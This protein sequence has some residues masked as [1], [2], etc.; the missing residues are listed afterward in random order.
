[1]VLQIG[2]HVHIGR[3]RAHTEAAYAEPERTLHGLRLQVAI[4]QLQ[5]ELT[6]SRR[7]EQAIRDEA[8][9]VSKSGGMQSIWCHPST[10]WSRCGGNH[11]S[12]VAV[13][14]RQR[15]G[16]HLRCMQVCEEQAVQLR[17][18][19]D[20]IR[21]LDDQL[22]Q[23]LSRTK[24][25]QVGSGRMLLRG[26]MGCIPNLSHEALPVADFHAPLPVRDA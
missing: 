17:Q 10:W 4:E 19:E 18:A 3:Y 22:S 7:E 1:M 20:Q 15:S 12:R 2:P 8:N 16:T 23:A 24:E 9:R 26:C 14:T 11:Q 5:Q 25:L 13:Q 6:A 21:S